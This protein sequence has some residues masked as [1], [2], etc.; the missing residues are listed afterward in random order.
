[1]HDIVKSSPNYN[2]LVSGGG[3]GS[4]LSARPKSDQQTTDDLPEIS[5]PGTS[6]DDRVVYNQEEFPVGFIE[7]QIVL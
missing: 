7:F 1:M 6:N 3:G 4:E 5:V 2:V